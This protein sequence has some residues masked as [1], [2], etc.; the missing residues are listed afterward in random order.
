MQNRGSKAIKLAFELW[1]HLYVLGLGHLDSFS[2]REG[3]WAKVGTNAVFYTTIHT[4]KGYFA[5]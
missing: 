4:P 5:T 3:K 1:F 2:F